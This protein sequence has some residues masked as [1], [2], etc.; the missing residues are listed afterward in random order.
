MS[1]R[2][3]AQRA[4]SH[5]HGARMRARRLAILQ[6]RGVRRRNEILEDA[7]PVLCSG[8]SKIGQAGDPG[9][10][11]PVRDRGRSGARGAGR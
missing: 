4:Y 5:L 1:H 9:I 6:E 8:L 11:T 10:V 2:V 7:S 3:Q